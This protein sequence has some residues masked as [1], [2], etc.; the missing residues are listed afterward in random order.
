MSWSTYGYCVSFL[1]FWFSLKIILRCFDFS[2]V[3]LNNALIQWAFHV[4]A[5]P[6]HP[7]DELAFTASANTHPMPF[8][9]IFEPRATKTFE[10]VKE[11][12]EDYGV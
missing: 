4:R 7:I 2:S 5:D 10:G 8:K 9:V 6:A 3:F 11:L 12:F 1:L